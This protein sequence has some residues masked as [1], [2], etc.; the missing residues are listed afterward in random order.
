[1][2][3]C[4]IAQKIA[5]ARRNIAILTNRVRGGPIGNVDDA[6]LSEI[7]RKKSL[8]LEEMMTMTVD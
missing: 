6:C 5:C 2:P 7:D 3:V 4:A 1:M 8:A